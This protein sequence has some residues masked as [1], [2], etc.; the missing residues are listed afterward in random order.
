LKTLAIVQA[1]IGS[2]RFPGKVMSDLGPYKV[3]ELLLARL[4]RATS[5]D[6]IIV[7][8]SNLQIDDALAEQIKGLGVEVFRGD[9]QNVLSRFVDIAKLWEPQIIV[10]VTGDCP[11]IDPII[12]DQVVEGLEKS[13]AD[14]SSNVEP[15]SFP[16]GFDV[17]SFTTQALLRSLK[18]PNTTEEKEHVTTKMRQSKEFLRYNL[19]ARQDYS[20]IRATLDYREDLAVLRNVVSRVSDPVFFGWEEVVELHSSNPELFLPNL[21]FSGRNAN[22]QTPL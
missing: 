17:E 8:T 12:V 15:A 9:E 7:A 13:D 3:M 2:K 20:F 4:A 19:T 16:H 5:L 18:E 10:R 22:L 21:V 1:R 11:L 6:K 14:Y